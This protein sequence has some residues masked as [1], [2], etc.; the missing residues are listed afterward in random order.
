[1]NI[2]RDITQLIGRTPLV[3]LNRIAGDLPAEIVAK[4]ES[5]NP[6]AS[7]KDR[8]GLAMIEAAERDGSIEPGRTVLVE[9]TSGN[10]G[11]ALALVAAV[12]GYE[13]VLVMPDTMSS[14]RRVTLRAFGARLVLTPGAAGM[15]GAVEEARRLAR[16]IPHARVLE[17]F[18]N[19]A[20]PDVHRDTTAQ[21]IWEDTDGTV[22]AVVA[23]V[24]TGGT[25]TGIAQALRPRRPGFRAIAVEPATSPVL[26]GGRPGPHRI[27]GLGAGFI[28]EIVD[29]TLIDD[30]ITVSDDE[31]FDMARRMAREEGLLVGIS[32]GAAVA[33]AL[34]YAYRPENAHKLIVVIIPSFGERYLATELFAPYR[35]AGS[36]DLDDLL[37]A[38]PPI[39]G[40]VPPRRHGIVPIDPRSL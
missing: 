11:I 31:A 30:I 22:D 2:A 36:D 24:G 29:P 8:I 18:S 17:Q 10:T 39:G 15:R 1:M 21:E 6:A 16:A 25:L 35:Y 3:R 32:S 4:L 9:P 14:E 13:C 37:S 5:R 27:Q 20:N 33:A 34:H 28:P 7:V 26:S 19:P 38:D 12:K 40:P 23:G